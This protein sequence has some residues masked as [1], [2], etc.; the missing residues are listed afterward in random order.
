M[1]TKNKVTKEATKQKLDYQS[2]RKHHFI[3]LQTTYFEWHLCLINSLLRK[4]CNYGSLSDCSFHFRSLNMLSFLLLWVI[5]YSDSLSTGCFFT[6]PYTYIL[7]KHNVIK[8]GRISWELICVFTVSLTD[9]VGQLR[10][11]GFTL[12]VQYLLC[13]FKSSMKF[14][15]INSSACTS[16]KRLFF[17]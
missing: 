3:F 7:L 8:P 6:S 4:V 11:C 13:L 9:R 10:S 2:H 17:D 12:K 5:I 15:E 1:Q 14:V 16:P